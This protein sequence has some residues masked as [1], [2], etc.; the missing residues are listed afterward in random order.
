VLGNLG[1]KMDNHQSAFLRLFKGDILEFILR[2]YLII[3]TKKIKI[4]MIRIKPKTLEEVPE[5]AGVFE[6]GEK[7]MGF[8]PNDGLTMAFRPDILK[9]FLG[10]IQSI[11]AQGLVDDGLKRMIGLMSSAAAGC[12]YCQAHAAN[13]AS[14]RGIDFEKIQ[15]VW[16]FRTSNL[17]SEREKIALEIAYKAGMVPNQVSDEDFMQLKVHFSDEE[18]IEIVSVIAMYGFLNRWNSTLKT[19]LEEQP[20]GFFKNVMNI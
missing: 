17:F 13:S 14:N 3:S 16:D 8:V 4:T 15:A 19:Q 9:S 5:L 6:I 7:L 2:N 1:G 11:Y 18:I 10:L 20:D 12:E